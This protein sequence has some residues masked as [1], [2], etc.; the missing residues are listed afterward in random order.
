MTLYADLEQFIL[1]HRSHGDPTWWARSPS[2]AGYRV[3][4]LCPC[5]IV[6]SRWVTPEIAEHDLLRSGLPAFEAYAECAWVLWSQQPR[7]GGV[8]WTPLEPFTNRGLCEEVAKV[9]GADAKKDL[10]AAL[11]CWPDTM[12]PRGPKGK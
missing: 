7:E 3:R 2:P 10:N 5:G 11:K 12:D 4:L 8:V 6:F 1:T 9:A